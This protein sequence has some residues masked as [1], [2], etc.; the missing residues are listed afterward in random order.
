MSQVIITYLCIYFTLPGETYQYSYVINSINKNTHC[1]QFLPCCVKTD[2][3]R[4]QVSWESVHLVQT[5][6][7]TN[8]MFSSALSSDCPWI[9]SEFNLCFPS[10]KEE[11]SIFIQKQQQQLEILQTLEATFSHVQQPQPVP[12]NNPHSN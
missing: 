2:N 12:P 7:G 11:P 9:P 1:Y 5:H 4:I 3:C 8:M 10:H 6:T